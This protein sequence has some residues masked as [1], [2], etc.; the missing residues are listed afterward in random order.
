V[1]QPD[2]K[3]EPTDTTV[4]QKNDGRRYET[5]FFIFFQSVSTFSYSQDLRKFNN[6]NDLV[7]GQQEHCCFF[8]KMQ[9]Q[10]GGSLPMVLYP[11]FL[12]TNHVP[13]IQ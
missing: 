2:L 6:N 7:D 3:A 9:L 1:P 5:I 13:F 8:L 11:V 4:T 10:F 12:G